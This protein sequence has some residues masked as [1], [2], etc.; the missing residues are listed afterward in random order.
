M[1]ITTPLGCWR[2]GTR[3]RKRKGASWQ[4]HVVGYYSTRLT[5][6]GYCVESERETG[7]VQIYPASALEP[8]ENEDGRYSSMPKDFER[9]E[10]LSPAEPSADLVERVARAIARA[11]GD[12]FAN[13][14]KD[15]PR[16]TAKRGMSGG[17]Y[18]DINEPFQSDYLD[19]ALAAIKEAGRP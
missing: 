3:V 10:N 4:G 12:E 8:V 18:R 13:A 2:I 17:R 6:I 16:W 19:M 15:K 14:F 7:S 5:D 11:N 9:R 1:K